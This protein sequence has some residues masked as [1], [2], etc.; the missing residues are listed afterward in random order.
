MP[1]PSSPYLRLRRFVDRDLAAHPRPLS[2]YVGFLP[3]VAMGALGA[4]MSGLPSLAGWALAVCCGI[5]WTGFVIWRIARLGKAAGLKGD[6]RYD[7]RTR[8][9]LA[10]EYEETESV[11]AARRRRSR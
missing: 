8:F 10:A 11:T 3:A 5:C 9:I 6:R 1:L 4:R 2:P 7:R